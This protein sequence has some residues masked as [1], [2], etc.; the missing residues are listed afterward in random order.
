MKTDA[1][2]DR[3]ALAS[4]LRE[5]SDLARERETCNRVTGLAVSEFGLALYERRR[6]LVAAMTARRLDMIKAAGEWDMLGA[7]VV[8]DAVKAGDLTPQEIEDG[9]E[10]AQ[11][12]QFA[13]SSGLVLSKLTA[14]RDG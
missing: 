6:P 5:P 10:L 14:L 13:E 1:R 2:R 11:D 8:L 9:I 4:V 7:F 12:K 3:S